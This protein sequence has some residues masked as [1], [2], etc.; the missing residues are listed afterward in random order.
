MGMTK[1]EVLAR[2]DK[3]RSVLERMPD[4]TGW[5]YPSLD[6]FNVEDKK[7]SVFIILDSEKFAGEKGIEIP[8]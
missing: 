8:L 1:Q 6:G 2:M 3:L 7:P 5:V 4:E